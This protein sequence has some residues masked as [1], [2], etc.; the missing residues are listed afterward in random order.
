MA[1]HRQNMTKAVPP[2]KTIGKTSNSAALQHLFAGSPIHSGDVNDEERI[3]LMKDLLLGDGPI[4]K[5]EQSDDGHTFSSVNLNY[6][7]A[8]GAPDYSNVPTGGAGL[9]ASPWVPNPSS[10]ADGVNN[11]GSIPEA[12]D[13]YG[14]VP[15]DNWGS[16]VGSQLSPSASAKAISQRDVRDLP[17]TRSS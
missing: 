11:P 4:T 8:G 7:G 13:G 14:T 10:P 3:A 17:K 9:P 6:E 16:G 1:D 5:G 12:P 15:A 2:K